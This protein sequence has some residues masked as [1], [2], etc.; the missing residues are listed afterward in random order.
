MTHTGNIIGFA[1]GF[2]PLNRIPI[3][4]S[5]GGSQ[6]RKFCVITEIILVF[7]IW[8]TCTIQE[9]ERPQSLERQGSGQISQAI[10]NIKVAITQLPKPIRRVCFVQL[11]AFMGW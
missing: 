10:T 1:I 8:A 9:K 2:L 7:T 4:R 6:F 3:I 5:L 11:F